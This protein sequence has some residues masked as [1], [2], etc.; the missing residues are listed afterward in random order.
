MNPRDVS[1]N[2]GGKTLIVEKSNRIIPRSQFINGIHKMRQR[3]FEIDSFLVSVPA[4]GTEEYAV[5]VLLSSSLFY[6]LCHYS[7]VDRYR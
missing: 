5:S 7:T 1:G 3:Q 2:R 4:Y 6:C